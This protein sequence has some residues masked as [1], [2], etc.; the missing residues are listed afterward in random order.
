MKY[1]IIMITILACGLSMVSWSHKTKS[2]ESPD[3]QIKI[4]K[5]IAKEIAKFDLKISYIFDEFIGSLSLPISDKKHFDL[6][7]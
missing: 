7:I 4:L 6:K 3:F 5:E 1:L 2:N